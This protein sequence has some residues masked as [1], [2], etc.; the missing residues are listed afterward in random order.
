[1]LGCTA[2]VVQSSLIFREAH[3]D[4]QKHTVLGVGAKQ[5]MRL[6]ERTGGAWNFGAVQ[7]KSFRSHILL[8]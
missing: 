7:S 3:R 2:G 1:M 5:D 6:A 4:S 8:Q